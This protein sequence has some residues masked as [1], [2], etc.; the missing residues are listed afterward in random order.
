M[1]TTKE[2]HTKSLFMVWRLDNGKNFTVSLKSPKDELT[3]EDVAPV[4]QYA[5]T[6][7]VFLVGTARVVEA[8]DAY[9]RDTT[10]LDL[11]TE[12]V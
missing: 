7:N 10:K 3:S 4:M 5:V 2:T 9:V 8:V 12:G 11:N 6:N 1:A